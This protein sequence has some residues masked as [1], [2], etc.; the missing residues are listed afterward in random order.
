MSGVINNKRIAK[1]TVLLYMRTLVV[2]VISLY[3]S[4]I[5]LKALG[6]SDFG[7]YQAV[8]GLVAIFS[9]ISNALVSAI[10]RFITYAIGNGDIEKQKQVYS[11]SKLIQICIAIVVFVVAEIVGTWFLRT[12]M[13][14]PE[15]RMTATIWVLQCSILT[16]CISLMNVPYVACITAHE[17]MRVFA[18][19]SLIEAV[20]KL[21]ICFLILV[22][23]FDQL[24]SY[25]V[26]LA[27]I[28]LAIQS[29]YAAYCRRYFAESRVG[30]KWNSAVFRE[31]GGFA[32]WSFFT[33]T[34]Y[35]LNTQGVNMLF[36]VFFGVTANAA[37]G[38]ANQVEGAVMSFV[39]NFT[40][41]INPQITKSYAAGEIDGMYTLVCRGAKFSYMAMLLFAIPI[42]LEAEMIL[43]IWLPEVPPHTISFVRL[44]L[45]LGML[46]CLG[47]SSFTACMATGKLRKY[48]LIVTPLGALEF[49]LAWIF[50]H[51][52]APVVSAYY[53]YVVVKILV[54]VARLYL[55]RTML[56]FAP[57][58]FVKKVY[59]RI[60]PMT[61]VSLILPLLSA[62][63]LP[64]SFVRL[65]ITTIFS[66]VSVCLCA[67][68]IGMTQGE[69]KVIFTKVADVIHSRLLR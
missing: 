19:F 42:I 68:Y 57:M 54:L 23:P 36:N 18:G 46:D 64:S 39:G 30:A 49:P 61:V 5:V 22:S 33:N 44:C 37:R 8:G 24:I 47:Q 25:A 10:S 31:I 45:I 16:F 12:K 41:A 26:L 40:T 2:M 14:I 11:S 66:V 63:F 51:Y 60:I 9:I 21:C 17:R 7:V 52:G 55:M 59:L 3:T 27:T 48:A 13:Q 1:N 28:S 35:L 43:E 56:G 38:I 29:G 15:G 20:A 65:L 6:I 67:L 32:G 50:F 69:R 53:L 34:T 58:T 4:R 62:F